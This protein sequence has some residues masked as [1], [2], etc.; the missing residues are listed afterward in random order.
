MTDKEYLEREL[1]AQKE[2]FESKLAALEA[3]VNAKAL[4][5]ASAIEKAETASEKRFSSVNEFRAQQS[6]IIS[7]FATRDA[8]A[9]GIREQRTATDGLIV[10]VNKNAERLSY[11]E[12]RI[13]VYVG[14]GTTVATSLAAL[15]AYFGHILKP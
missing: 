12:G 3:L 7:N 2:L 10:Q 15:F 8:L 11:L 5:Q 9:S 13:L 1:A 6:D 4:A 14:V